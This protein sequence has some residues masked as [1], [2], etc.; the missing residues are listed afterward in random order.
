[1][2]YSLYFTKSAIT[3]PSISGDQIPDPPGDEL[4]LPSVYIGT[5]F[6]VD[7]I[8]TLKLLE[9]DVLTTIPIASVN[10]AFNDINYTGLSFTVTDSNPSA[11]TIRVSGSLSGGVGGG[12]S[13]DFVL[14]D[15]PAFTRTT[16]EVNQLPNNFLAI[17]NWTTPKSI[18]TVLSNVYTFT[19]NGQNAHET[20]N[21]SF[22]QYV[23]WN[24]NPALTAFEQ[25][26]NQGLV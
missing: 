1:M 23:Y 21:I 17:Y 19:A 4:Y 18:S 16:N 11:Y 6:I 2:S 14:N 26:V 5:S 24:W 8:F 25:I 7:I 9:G 22:S 20:S 13:Y 10:S 15:P 12:E 3:V